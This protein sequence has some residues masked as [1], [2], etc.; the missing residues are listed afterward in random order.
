MITLSGEKILFKGG[1]RLCYLHPDDAGK[2]VKVLAPERRPDAVRRG[3]PV[4]KKLRPLASFDANLREWKILQRIAEKGDA[5]WKHIPRCF[6]MVETDL[7]SAFCQELIRSDD[8]S[9]AP[10]L[11][12]YLKRNGYTEKIEKALEDFYSFLID[13]TVTFRDMHGRNLV[14]RQM[15]DDVRIYLID[16]IGSS[17]FLPIAEISETWAKHSIR[18]KIERFKKKHLWG[19]MQF[20]IKKAG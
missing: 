7:G 1:D 17:A 9:I 5:V 12:V 15:K 4:Y 20:E 10:T 19:R 18:K 2:I 13:N 16:G 11:G 6:G 3:A 8:G 14:V